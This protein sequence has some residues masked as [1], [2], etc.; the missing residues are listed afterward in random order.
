MQ[1]KCDIVSLN[2]CHPTDWEN[3]YKAA[4]HLCLDCS[5]IWQMNSKISAICLELVE[6]AKKGLGSKDRYLKATL[7]LLGSCSEFSQVC[8][9]PAILDA[10]SVWIAK[11]ATPGNFVSWKVH[12]H[13]DIVYAATH[14]YRDHY[15]VFWV[16]CLHMGPS[17][18][19]TPDLLFI[20]FWLQP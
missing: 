3:P 1:S 13:S 6:I 9:W 12:V 15:L 19:L 11:V 7:N 14:A 17:V 10:K 4:S 20:G 18:L 16:S 2:G 8:Q 5:I